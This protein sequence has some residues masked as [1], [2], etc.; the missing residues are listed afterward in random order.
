MVISNDF[1]RLLIINFDEHGGFADH[2]PP[3]V[4]I[5]IPEDGISFSGVSDAHNVTYNFDRLG[6]RYVPSTSNS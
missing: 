2:V 1:Y 5:P 4:N 6:L 3:P